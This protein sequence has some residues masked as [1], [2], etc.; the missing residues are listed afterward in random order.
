[1]VVEGK[2]ADV[3]FEISVVHGVKVLMW[4]ISIL[5]HCILPKYNYLC[6]N[7]QRKDDKSWFII[8]YAWLL[9]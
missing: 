7:K 6:F 1:A 8:G 9:G 3:T 4:H 2:P 5:P